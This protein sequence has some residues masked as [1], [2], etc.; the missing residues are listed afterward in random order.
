MEIVGQ[1]IVAIRAMTS[2]EL[3][4]QYWDESAPV[5]ELEDGTILYPSRDE[6]GNGP[7]CVFGVDSKGTPFGLF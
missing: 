7:G 3:S 1:K 2:K 5:L 6:E 4:E